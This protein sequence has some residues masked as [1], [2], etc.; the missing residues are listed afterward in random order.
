MD[1]DKVAAD[2]KKEEK[3]EQLEGDQVGGRAHLGAG[4]AEGGSKRRRR[5]PYR[6]GRGSLHGQVLICQGMHRAA[7]FP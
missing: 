5:W 2:V 3:E 1:W 4:G 6:A 7:P